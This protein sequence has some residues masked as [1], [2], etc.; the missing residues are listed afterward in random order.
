MKQYA[1]FGLRFVATFIDVLV[2]LA[3]IFLLVFILN[4]S[5]ENLPRLIVF[6]ILEIAFILF[7]LIFYPSKTGQTLGKKV[8]GIKIV[9]YQGETPSLLIFLL[10]EI[11]AK[12]I[13]SWF[14]FIG[15][16]WMLWDKKNQTWHDKIART[17]VV[18]V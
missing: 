8:I 14:L 9:N 7:Y 6:N 13:S 18:E 16:F 17:Y 10:R 5:K 11:I 4:P 2:I 3:V 1:S 15:Y 12:N